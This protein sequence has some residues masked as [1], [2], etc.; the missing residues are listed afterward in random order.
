MTTENQID[1]A[2]SDFAVRARLLEAFGGNVDGW[3]MTS[4]GYSDPP[5][6]VCAC[7]HRPLMDL[8]FWTH[9]DRPGQVVTTGSTCVFT[10]P[11]LDPRSLDRIR[12]H[13]E[14]LRAKLAED[15]RKA[16]EAARTAEVSELLARILAALCSRYPA[17]IAYEHTGWARARSD[18]GEAKAGA[19]HSDYQWRVRRVREALRLK[20]RAGQLSRLRAL[21]A[22]L[23]PAGERAA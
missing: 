2:E 4:T 18:Y 19:Q 8:Y 13:V 21:L 20:S 11:G 14:Q 5:D 23:E 15:K 16:R 9:P 12:E 1:R 17:G 10:V 7:G 22:C 3:E 6:G